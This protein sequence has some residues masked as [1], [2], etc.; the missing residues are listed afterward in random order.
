M[1]K[2]LQPIPRL[3]DQPEK[4]VFWTWTEI[5]LFMSIFLSVWG[6]FSFLLG[7]ILGAASIRLLRLLKNS[8]YGDLTKVGLYW[9]SPWSHKRFKTLADS[10]IREYI[11]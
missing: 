2:A 3:L 7:F 11:G 8:P 5:M 10:R 4:I 6:A 9:F 1:D